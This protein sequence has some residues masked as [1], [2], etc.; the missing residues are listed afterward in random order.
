ME[1][2]TTPVQRDDS[3]TSSLVVSSPVDVTPTKVFASEGSLSPDSVEGNKPAEDVVLRELKQEPWVWVNTLV[4]QCEDL[5]RSATWGVHDAMSA[6]SDADDSSLDLGGGSLL[7]ER[8]VGKVS[9]QPAQYR[10]DPPDHAYAGSMDGLC[11]LL[12]RRNFAMR[13]TPHWRNAADF[14]Q[15][16]SSASHPEVGRM[17]KS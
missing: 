11:S 4:V 17:A 1:T 9:V 5:I 8:S 7:A 6:E 13:V 3:I 14:R 15:C 2:I 10:L 12:D 16:G